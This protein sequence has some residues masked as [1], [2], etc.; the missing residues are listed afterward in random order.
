[1][2]GRLSKPISEMDGYCIPYASMEREYRRVIHY[3]PGWVSG[4]HTGQHN[5]WTLKALVTVDGEQQPVNAEV[6]LDVFDMEVTT[7]L[8]PGLKDFIG[9]VDTR[10]LMDFLEDP[11]GPVEMQSLHTEFEL[12]IGRPKAYRCGSTV[13]PFVSVRVHTVEELRYILARLFKIPADAPL[14]Y[15]PVQPKRARM[16]R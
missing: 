2:A 6:M 3:A 5:K 7:T 11:D 4:D 8:G 10:L 9:V 14:V 15:V 1:M 12:G 16:Q 13:K